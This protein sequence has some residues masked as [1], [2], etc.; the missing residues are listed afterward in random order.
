VEPDTA[1]RILR[2]SQVGEVHFLVRG[3]SPF[4]PRS[5]LKK[6]SAASV[7]LPGARP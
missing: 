4:L 3:S 7:N 1:L 2:A 6:L 5:N